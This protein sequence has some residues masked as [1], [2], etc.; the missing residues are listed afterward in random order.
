[1]SFHQCNMHK[2]AKRGSE[3]SAK[4]TWPMKTKATKVKK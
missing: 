4:G 1:M 2:A 3:N